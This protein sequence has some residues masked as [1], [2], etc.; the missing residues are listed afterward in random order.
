MKL[1]SVNDV[2]VRYSGNIAVQNV[3]MDIFS[4]DFIGIIGPNG[5]GKT[6]IIKAI[7]G[8][9][10][11][12]GGITFSGTYRNEVGYLPQQNNFDRSFPITVGELIL[13]GLQASR[14]TSIGFTCVNN[15]T[16]ATRHMR[17]TNISH[18]A[19]KGIA[20]LSGG[21]LQRALLCRALI[22]N[23]KL[24]ILDEPATY[25]D[26]KF[27]HELYEILKQLNEKMAIV[28]VSHDINT[29][30]SYVKSAIFVNKTVHRHNADE[31]SLDLL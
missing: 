12:E 4:D 26:S 30:K 21:E 14:A 20:E 25:V 22:S 6:S 9:V 15:K 27:E 17:L 2:T 5:G 24:L 13:S 8:L 29:I 10:P 16:E 18:L 1:L 7:L 11:Y 3:F 31:L 19:D 28:M 23:P